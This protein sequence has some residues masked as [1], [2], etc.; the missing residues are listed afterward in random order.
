MT[1]GHPYDLQE[2]DRFTSVVREYD[3]GRDYM[4]AVMSYGTREDY[5][6]SVSFRFA[7]CEDY[8]N[9][10]F[11][12]YDADADTYSRK[13]MWRTGAC[14]ANGIPVFQE[15]V[16]QDKEG[17]VHRVVW[18]PALYG[19]ALET[20]MEG[21]TQRAFSH[22]DWTRVTIIGDWYQTRERV[23]FVS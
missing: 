5:D 19:W 22:V 13:L 1:N 18:A 8:G 15:D 10:E 6:D 20:P 16:L 11:Y 21:T 9:P 12:D 7:H 3:S 2:T 4:A 17:T 14:D 23:S